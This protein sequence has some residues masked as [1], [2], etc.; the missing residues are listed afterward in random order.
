[1]KRLDRADALLEQV[2]HALGPLSD[3]VRQEVLVEVAGED[4]D[5]ELRPAAPELDRREQ[6]V[7][8]AT[9][10]HLDVDDRDVGSQGDRLPE[11]VGS[12]ARVTDDVEADLGEDASD[13]LAEEEV[14]LADH[15]ANRLRHIATVTRRH[16]APAPCRRGRSTRP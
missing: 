15:D 12:V 2:P 13:A 16:R 8:A 11:Q 1:V 4:Q 3:Q 6:P 10:R 9:R 5:P 14:V 7:V